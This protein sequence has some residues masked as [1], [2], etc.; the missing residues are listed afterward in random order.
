MNTE[1]RAMIITIA[2]LVLIVIGIGASVYYF[3][4][5]VLAEKK[6]EL[7]QAEN[8]VREAQAKK[9]K[10][11]GLLKQIEDLKKQE[12]ELIKHIPNLTRAEYDDLANLL[13]GLR[14]RSGVFV[15][16]ARWATPQRRQPVAGLPQRTVPTTVHK[17]Q[18]DLNVEGSFYQL[19]R[20]VNLLEQESRFINVESFS[21]SKASDSDSG[22]KGA[23][24]KRDMKVTIYS[25]TYKPLTTEGPVIDAAELRYGKS[26]D[27]PD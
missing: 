12:A 8:A 9:D 13:D 16:T 19:L 24:P 15:D 3:H 18:Y 5:T 14:R 22:P 4:F 2:C 25:Y 10:I 7:A 11:P 20:Y 23:A 1:K 27:I 21:I 26:T 6:A 17:V